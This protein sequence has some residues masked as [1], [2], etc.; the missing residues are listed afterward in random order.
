MNDDPRRFPVL[1]QVN[2]R[3]HLSRLVREAG[4]PATLDDV[5]DTTLDRIEA[6]GVDWLYLLG[7]WQ[8]GA[9]GRA[10]RG[11]T[12]ASGPTVPPPCPT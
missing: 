12:P 4:R 3:T 9:A 5:A 11:R 6:D 8:T 7:V 1:Y 10:Y 2:T